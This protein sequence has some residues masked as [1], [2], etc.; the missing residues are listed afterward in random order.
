MGKDT[1]EK[2]VELF[3]GGLYCSE[4]ILKVLNDKYNIGLNEAGLKMATAFG[5]GIGGSK[6]LCGSLTGVVLAASAIYGRTNTDK[7]E[8]ELFAISKELH[9]NFKKEYGAT[10]CRVLTKD[11]EWGSDDHFAHCIKLVDGAVKIF[12]N[13]IKRGENSGIK[14]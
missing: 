12:E 9:D 7:K 5:A 8:D 11:K 2:A 6:C 1:A 10:C 4:A 13:I 3:K 14:S